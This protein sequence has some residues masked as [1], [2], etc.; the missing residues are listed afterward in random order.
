MLVLNKV[1]RPK[2][3]ANVVVETAG[4]KPEPCSLRSPRSLPLR[5]ARPSTNAERNQV[6]R[7]QLAAA[8]ADSC[9]KA[10]NS[11]MSVV[12]HR[13]LSNSGK[14]KLDTAA[15]SRPPRKGARE[16]EAQRRERRGTRNVESVQHQNCDHAHKTDDQ[17]GPRN[18]SAF[19]KTIKCIDRRERDCE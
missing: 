19:L 13:R 2:N 10:P 4:V 3:L 8:A 5:G 16:V 1:L 7:T 14:T 12:T 15:S 11:L 6:P 18:S 17:A 9:Q